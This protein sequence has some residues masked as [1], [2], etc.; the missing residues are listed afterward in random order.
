MITRSISW[1]KRRPVRKAD[2]LPPSCAVVTK[3]GNL[4]FLEP[5][6]PVQACNG[7]ALPLPLLPFTCFTCVDA[8]CRFKI[9]YWQLRV[10]IYMSFPL[11]S[12]FLD[13]KILLLSVQLLY[14]R[15]VYNSLCTTLILS[16]TR[17]YF[18]SLKHFFVLCTVPQRSFKELFVVKK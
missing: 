15:K 14:G 4:N 1:G 13:A 17:R 2:N 5:S 8:C 18:C 12:I 9:N 7:T 10:N 6:G 16:N 3:S 11:I